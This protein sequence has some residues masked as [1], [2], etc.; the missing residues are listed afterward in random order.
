MKAISLKP[1]HDFYLAVSVDILTFWLLII[2]VTTARL[3]L[4]QNKH[5]YYEILKLKD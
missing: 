3:W 2:R 4:G 5:S 1:G